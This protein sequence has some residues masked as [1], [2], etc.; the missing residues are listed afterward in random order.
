[1]VPLG[2]FVIVLCVL[3]EVYKS[4]FERWV[5][6]LTDWL[7]KREKWSWTIPVAILFV[8]SFPPLFGH[9]IVQ[10]IVGLTY[11]LGVALGIA[12]AGSILGEAGCFVV[13]KYCFSGY[14][15]K[16]I[17]QKIKWAA[18]A[19]VAQQAG[20]KG[21]LVIRYSIVPPHLANP[22]FACT[23]MKF[24]LYMSTVI[25]SLP[26]SMVFVA[27]GAPSSEHS[28]G[29]KVGKVIAIGIVVAITSK[30]FSNY[31]L[32]YDLLIIPSLC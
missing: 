2:I 22:L 24:W 23:G 3:F 10:L 28:K 12:C 18:T 11:P 21:V 30:A 31:S 1:M 4:D 29:A 25:L 9:E 32:N 14:V 7:R 16:K 6:P 8:L 15:E 27:L 19:R 17:R 20:F 13:F 5:S 26:K